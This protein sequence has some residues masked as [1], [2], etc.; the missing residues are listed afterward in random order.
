MTRSPVQLDA[1][2]GTSSTYI[3]EADVD[4]KVDVHVIDSSIFSTETQGAQGK[5]IGEKEGDRA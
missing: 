1:Q 2:A 4:V 3:E 5:L